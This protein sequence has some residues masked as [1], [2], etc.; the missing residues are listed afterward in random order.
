MKL[1]RLLD[2][3][4]A[5]KPDGFIKHLLILLA[6]IALLVAFYGTPTMRLALTGWYVLP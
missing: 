2:S 4:L 1:I 5:G 3:W 6:I